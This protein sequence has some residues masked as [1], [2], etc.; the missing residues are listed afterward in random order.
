[1]YNT[2][3][4]ELIKMALQKKALIEKFL[5]LTEEQST[6]IANKNYENMFKIIN[7]KQSI[8]EKVNILDLQLEDTIAENRQIVNEI[9]KTTK[10]IM[11]KAIAL[12]TQ[13]IQKL[14]ENQ[15]E[16]STKLKELRKNKAG[17]DQYQGKNA[18]IGGI[19]LD[20]KK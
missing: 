1:M 15:L 4:N 2:D 20:Y 19:F 8:I 12:D 3:K 14:K 9:T 10:K 13:N 16:I 18:N 7:E 6:A 17:H 5:F 11:S